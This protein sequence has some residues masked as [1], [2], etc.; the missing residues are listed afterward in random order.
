MVSRGVW[1]LY[2]I[3]LRFCK[4]GG[5]SKGVRD[6]LAT[7]KLDDF[8]EENQQ[9]NLDAYQINGQHPYIQTYY[10]NGW[11]RSYP[12]RNLN[13]D[14]IIEVL[15]RARD[16]IGHAAYKH[17]GKKVVSQVKSV[18]GMWHHSFWNRSKNFEMFHPQQVPQFPEYST[19]NPNP[20]KENLK[21]RYDDYHR[22]V[23][24]KDQGS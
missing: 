22:W 24:K 10:R 6:L 5:S 23:V 3:N 4:H 16:Q 14:E 19:I 13:E 18:Q 8:L 20:K 1:S 17:S 2:K 7:Q 12:L 21:S 9:I 11:E 15:Q